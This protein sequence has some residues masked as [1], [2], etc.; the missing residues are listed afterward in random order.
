MV[1]ILL[2]ALKTD[3]GLLADPRYKNKQNSLVSYLM[4]A[5]SI[6]HL[7]DPSLHHYRINYPERSANLMRIY[8]IETLYSDSAIR[9]AIDIMKPSELQKMFAIP[10]QMLEAQEVMS[11]YKVLN[12]YHIVAFDG[13]EHY[14]NT[15]AKDKPCEH[16]LVK[17]HRNKKGEVT[18]TTY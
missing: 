16:C 12:D 6:F 2:N 17:E 15:T 3:F 18:K 8:G 5:F 10:L 14:C 1:D 9:E 13:T 7:K 11:K 4:S